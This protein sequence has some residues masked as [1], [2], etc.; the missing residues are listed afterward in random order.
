M[1][2]AEWSGKAAVKHQKDIADPLEIGEMDGISLQIIKA[3][4]WCGLVDF[5]S[6]HD[7]LFPVSSYDNAW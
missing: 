7:L 4:I 1:P 3:E 5:N 2:L 6:W